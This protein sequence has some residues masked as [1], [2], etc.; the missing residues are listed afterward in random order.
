MSSDQLQRAE[1]LQTSAPDKTM[2]LLRVALVGADGEVRNEVA[3]H[4]SFR[5]I[6][7]YEINSPV[8]GGV[9]GFALFTVEGTCAFVS[10]DF[11]NQPEL[12]ALRAPGKYRAEV[13]VPSQ[14]LNVGRYSLRISIATTTD[15]YDDIE[16]L[17]FSVLDT[18][19]PGSRNGIQRRGI[20]QPILDWTTRPSV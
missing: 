1:Y 9:V 13:M 10:A 18:G 12:L 15:V 5:F 11:D 17:V 16:A 8:I 19:T 2:N 3:Y 6:V 20:L 7:E 14:W 4:E